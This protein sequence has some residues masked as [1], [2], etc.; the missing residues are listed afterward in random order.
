MTRTRSK[1]SWPTILPVK[2]ADQGC[3]HI[4][5]SRSMKMRYWAPIVGLQPSFSNLAYL[6]WEA[7][8]LKVSSPT[9][10]PRW[11][12][13]TTAVSKTSPITIRGPIP[14]TETSAKWTATKSGVTSIS[15]RAYL[16]R[17]RRSPLDLIIWILTP[18]RFRLIL[19]HQVWSTISC[20]VKTSGKTSRIS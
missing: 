17:D 12:L 1:G 3:L 9:S 15:S 7:M 10:C 19:M 2:T 18:W 20:R 5:P 6:I 14:T 16:T 13:M 11:H 8:F 4:L